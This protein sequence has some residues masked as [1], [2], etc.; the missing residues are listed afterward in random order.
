MMIIFIPKRQ[1]L[2]YSQERWRK[3]ILQIM[4]Q[5][6]SRCDFKLSGEMYVLLIFGGLKLV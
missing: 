6:A 3:L 2:F 4:L 5:V 1:H